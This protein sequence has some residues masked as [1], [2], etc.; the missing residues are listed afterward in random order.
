MPQAGQLAA[1]D[2]HRIGATT[3]RLAAASDSF[4]A[5]RTALGNMVV[6]V[7]D[8][9]NSLVKPG[10]SPTVLACG[11]TN[12]RSAGQLVMLTHRVK[13]CC[14]HVVVMTVGAIS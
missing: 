9:R 3:C 14:Q 12:G 13:W 2:D 5:F 11:D 1:H 10:M 7:E 8:H 6:A 4:A